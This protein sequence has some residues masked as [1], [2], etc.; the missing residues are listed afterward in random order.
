MPKKDSVNCWLAE[1]RARMSAISTCP[2]PST[3]V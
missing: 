1:G 3:Q 2:P